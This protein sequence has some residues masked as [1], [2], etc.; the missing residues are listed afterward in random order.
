MSGARSHLTFTYLRDSAHLLCQETYV[1]PDSISEIVSAPQNTALYVAAILSVLLLG[2]GLLNLRGRAF[3]PMLSRLLARF[4]KSRDYTEE[5]F[6]SAD[7]APTRFIEIRR[8]ALSALQ[9]RLA[10]RGAKSSAWADSMRSGLSDL[11]FTDASR[12]PF[13]FAR[14]MREGFNVASVAVASAGSRLLDLDGN[15]NIDVSGSY[16][17]NVAGYDRYK[18]WLERGW[19]RVRDLG[20]V[21]GPLHPIVADN[22][23]LLK[24]ISGQNEVSFHASG[25][26]AV[27][28][29][30]RLVRFN[31]RRK[32]IV[33]FSGAYHG[34]WDGVQPGLGSE[35]GIDD[36]LTLK[37]LD[38]ASL[39]VIRR[40]AG[41]IAG[42][43]VNPIQAFHPNSPP[44]ND[45]T[46]LNSD[47]RKTDPNSSPYGR[48]L[49]ELRKV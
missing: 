7:G 19:R 25:T 24:A 30:T 31:T 34:W 12:V 13:P 4:I 32:L 26:E 15:W 45:A 42:V 29:A 46:L 14:R 20:P 43:L 11:R 2:K 40:R 23:T 5:G 22:I 21:L 36:C 16:G 48:W 49:K 47:I 9:K 38:P 8:A 17:V 3:T 44:P 37:D 1:M 41:A 10:A 33:C 18:E 28:A 39:A 6:L 35:R 27:M